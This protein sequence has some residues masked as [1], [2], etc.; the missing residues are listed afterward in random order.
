MAEESVSCDSSSPSD[1]PLYGEKL[2]QWKGTEQAVSNSK[3]SQ[4][5]S[6]LWHLAGRAGV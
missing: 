1:R 4:G 5:P 3:L 2:Q 6:R